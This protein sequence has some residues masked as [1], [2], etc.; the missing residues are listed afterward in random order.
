MIPKLFKAI[1]MFLMYKRIFEH[2]TPA[3]AGKAKKK[4]I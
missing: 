3:G 4:K 2:S 1:K